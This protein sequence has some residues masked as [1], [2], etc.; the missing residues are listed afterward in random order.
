MAWE[1]IVTRPMFTRW[2]SVGRS[3]IGPAA[4]GTDSTTAVAGVPAASSSTSVHESN[5]FSERIS[6]GTR[7]STN[8]APRTKKMPSTAT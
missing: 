7:E 3:A 4:A 8:T 6:A 5:R 1:K 2:R